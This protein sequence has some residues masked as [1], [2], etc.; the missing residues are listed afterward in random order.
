M[1][2]TVVTREKSYRKCNI[3]S[4]SKKEFRSKAWQ[5][6]SFFPFPERIVLNRCGLANLR[7]E[8]CPKLMLAISKVR[9]FI[10]NYILLKNQP[11]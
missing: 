10:I 8:N 6:A 4:Y 7:Q 5:S 9:G 3:R 1:I 2:I 11:S